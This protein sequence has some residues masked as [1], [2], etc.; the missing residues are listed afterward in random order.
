MTNDNNDYNPSKVMDKLADFWDWM[1]EF[2]K[3]RPLAVAGTVAGALM[4]AGLM[5][6]LLVNTQNNTTDIN[7]VTQEFCS[8]RPEVIQTAENKQ[9]C[10]AL[11]SR[12]LANPT[13]EQARQLRE[14][15]RDN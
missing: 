2:V 8:G 1:N 7:R 3:C 10:Q 15:V 14:I 6:Y 9:K 11:L 4:F 13:P 12:L 5:G